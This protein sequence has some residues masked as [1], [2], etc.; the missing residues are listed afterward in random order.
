MNRNRRPIMPAP[1][2]ALARRNTEMVRRYTAGESM[3]RIGASLG[4]TRERVRQ[5]VKGSGAVMPWDY[6]CAVADCAKAPRSAYQYCFAHQHRFERYGDPLGVRPLLREQH[7]TVPCYADGG[8]R[9]ALCRRAEADRRLEYEHR[10]HAARRSVSH[11][12]RTAAAS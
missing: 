4:L 10:V 6:I 3:A 11:T 7:G 9:C 8:C 12:P 5:I 1:R 2:P